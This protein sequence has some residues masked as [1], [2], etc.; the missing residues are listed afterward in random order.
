MLRRVNLP[1][2]GRVGTGWDRKTAA[3][4]RQSDLAYTDTSDGMVQHPSF[5]GLTTGNERA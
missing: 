3:A 1:L 2:G 4:I 5:K